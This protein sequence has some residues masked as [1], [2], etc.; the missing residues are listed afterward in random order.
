MRKVFPKTGID[1]PALEA[2]MAALSDEDIDWR[3]GRAPLYVFHGSDSAYEVGRQ[4][5]MKYFSENALGGRRA[6]FGLKRMED[7]VIEMG[8]D[9][10]QAPDGAV[11][12]MSTGGSESIFMA[13]KACRDWARGQT[14]LKEPFNIIA[15][16]TA[17]AAFNKA[18]DVMDLEV[19][20]LDT[21]ADRRADVGAMAAAV[22]DSTIMVVGSAPC[23]PH[24]VIDHI[25]ELSALALDRDIWLHVDACVGGYVAP[26]FQ[27]M[28]RRIPLY[29]FA[30]PGVRTLSADLHKFGFCPKPAS[31]LFYRLEEDRERG[32]FHFD[33]WPNGQFST[34]TLS[35]TRAGGAVAAAWAVMH[36]LG[37]DG[38]TA[39]AR[40]LAA[41]ADAYVS[42][43]KAIDGLYL[44]A[45]PDLT[46]INFAADDFDIFSVAE[47]MGTRGWLP[48]LTQ[49]P[50]GM[51]AML[52]MFHETGREEYLAD[53]ESCVE[54]VK[55]TNSQSGLKA[56]Y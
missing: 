27:R 25:E 23:F 11:G 3:H 39:I 6:F 32:L 8:L 53:L 29:D 9:L 22:D 49:N 31:T 50:K 5:F 48:G 13:V 45:D 44:V 28:G 15:P 43:I 51:H 40:D 47:A 52:S 41:M 30:L 18:A 10:F 36:H 1:W 46:I 33:Q 54:Q 4:A 19:R 17:H 38:Y 24:G 26:F 7:E 2:E 42:G 37:V 34:A 35:G 14:R 21:A 55:G 12:N 16:F 20:R 56:V